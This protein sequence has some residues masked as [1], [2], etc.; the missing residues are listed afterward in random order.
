MKVNK[1]S[2]NMIRFA[3]RLVHDYILKQANP[4]R[5]KIKFRTK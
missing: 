5:K 4:E 3:A 2:P 1:P